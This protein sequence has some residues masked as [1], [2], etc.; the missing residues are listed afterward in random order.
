MPK[1]RKSRHTRSIAIFG[2]L[3][4]VAMVLSWLEA[5][6]VPFIP[7]PGVRLGLTNLVVLVALYKL[8]E[9]EAIGLNLVRI[10]LVGLSFG[11]AFSLMYSLAGG[12]LSGLVMLLLKKTNRFNIVT[13]S[14]AGGIFHNVGQLLVAAAVLGSGA[15]L[16]YLV[17]LWISGIIAG[18]FIGLICAELLKRLPDFFDENE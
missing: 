15:V 13:V 5:Q 17:I 9:K 7:F 16:Y 3:V 1:S 14:V 2:L 8:G 4:A 11:N 12:L 18:A 10:L 6:L